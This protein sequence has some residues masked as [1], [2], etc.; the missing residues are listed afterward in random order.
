MRSFNVQPSLIKKRNAIRYAIGIVF[1]H[2]NPSTL[3]PFTPSS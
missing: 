2:N 3:P 1:N